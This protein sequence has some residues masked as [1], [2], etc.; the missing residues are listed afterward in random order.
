MFVT[1]FVHSQQ[2]VPRFSGELA[3]FRLVSPS[4]H[5]ESQARVLSLSAVLLVILS[6]LLF[7]DFFVCLPQDSVVLVIFDGRAQSVPLWLSAAGF[8]LWEGVEVA[9]AQYRIPYVYKVSFVCQ[10]SQQLLT[11]SCRCRLSGSHR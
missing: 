2:R 10:T 5:A 11:M 4:V 3:H 6:F 8:S 7:R 1:L 9:G